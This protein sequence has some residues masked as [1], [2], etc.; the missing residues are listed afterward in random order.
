[1]SYDES[2]RSITLNADASLAVWTS[3]P[4]QP[5]SA[6]PNTGKMYRFVKITGVRQCGLATAA[7]D[8]VVGVSQSKPQKLG[9]ATTVCFSGVTNVVVET[10][11]I[12]AG[13][14]VDP[15]AGGGAVKSAGAGK[16]IALATASSVGEIIP[17][18]L[19]V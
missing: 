7:A 2:Q 11:P 1:M 4:G 8:K 19:K 9:Q 14:A 16:G 13:D 10:L 18:L 3:V 6:D 5:G 15:A 12:A 17:V